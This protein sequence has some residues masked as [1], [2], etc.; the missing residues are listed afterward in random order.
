LPSI[1][2]YNNTMFLSDTILCVPRSL[3][4]PFDC[5]AAV[6]NR[7][8]LLCMSPLMYTFFQLVQRPLPD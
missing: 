5:I 1:H 6:E 2:P 8:C 7:P 4:L 3:L